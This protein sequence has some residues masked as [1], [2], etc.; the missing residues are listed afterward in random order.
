MDLTCLLAS[1][2]PWVLGAS[3]S[4]SIPPTVLLWKVRAKIA[5][6]CLS[7]VVIAFGFCLW[8]LG[9]LVYLWT[10]MVL[11]LLKR[12]G[13]YDAPVVWSGTSDVLI[14]TQLSLIAIPFLAAAGISMKNFSASLE[15]LRRNGD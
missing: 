10:A 13:I 11:Y 5:G 6:G 3:L 2:V 1:D 15:G 8:G 12:L 7:D 14:L 9:I 4:F